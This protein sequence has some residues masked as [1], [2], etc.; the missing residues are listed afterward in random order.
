MSSRLIDSRLFLLSSVPTKDDQQLNSAKLATY[1]EVLRSYISFREDCVRNSKDVTLTKC[2][3]ANQTVHELKE[4]YERANIP[5]VAP[6]IMC[7]RI[8]KFNAEFQS[9][10]KL[11]IARRQT[12]KI[13]I[14][15]F[16]HKLTTT[17][18]FWPKNVF[19][20]LKNEED[21]LF[22][23][24]MMNER[25]ASIGAEDRVFK[26]REEAKISKMIKIKKRIEKEKFRQA[27]NVHEHEKDTPDN[28][29]C[30]VEYGGMEEWELSTSR[31]HRRLTKTE[32][33]IF[34][35]FDILK[36]PSVV[37]CSTRCNISNGTLSSLMFAIITSCGGDPTKFN[38]HETQAFR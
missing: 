12:S 30:D 32:D 16:K 38:I 22:L 3:A 17:M 29:D 37:A 10:R 2:E 9:L 23:E 19:K 14:D 15:K 34:I 20:L 11:P 21:K 6:H 36:N 25:K 35:P 26:K 1:N 5:I 31:K 28:I 27:D 8:I 4:Q 13:A 18:P 7:E 33:N 24:D